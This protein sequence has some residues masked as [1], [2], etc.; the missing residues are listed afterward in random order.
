MIL[1]KAN[2]FQSNNICQFVFSSL[3]RDCIFLKE[4]IMEVDIFKHHLDRICLKDLIPKELHF[5]LS[6]I[7]NFYWTL[8]SHLVQEQ[9]QIR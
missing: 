1:C 7:S 2:S 4:P 5:L 6:V 9:V 3:L 8:V